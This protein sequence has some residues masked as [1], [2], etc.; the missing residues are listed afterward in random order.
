MFKDG[1]VFGKINLLDFTV[2][3]LILLCVI[4]IFVRYTESK[5]Q[6]KAKTAKYD[7]TVSVKNIRMFAVDAIKK[8]GAVLD[9][10]GN[11]LGE[12][13][14]VQEKEASD[15]ITKSDGTV[16]LSNIPERYDIT[17][18][19]ESNLKDIYGS[20]FSDGKNQINRGTKMKLHSKYCSFDSTIENYIKK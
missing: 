18:T 3:L 10:K 11:Y 9:Y 19:I 13:K 15:Y 16:V 6:Y 14:S 8:G 1:K 7:V 17:V 20:L 5:L 4:G 12:I 2:L